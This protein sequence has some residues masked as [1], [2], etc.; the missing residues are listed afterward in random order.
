MAFTSVFSVADIYDSSTSNCLY[1]KAMS[2]FD[3]KEIIV[4][5]S[6]K[7]FDPIMVKAF[8]KAFGIIEMELP[9]VVL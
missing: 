9:E 7:D 2:P 8:L 1:R 4:K 5:G 3:A 6:W